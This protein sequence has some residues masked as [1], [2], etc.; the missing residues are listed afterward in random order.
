MGGQDSGLAVKSFHLAGKKK[1]TITREYLIALVWWR[2]I[3][4]VMDVESE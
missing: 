1:R 3:I 2:K 4:Q